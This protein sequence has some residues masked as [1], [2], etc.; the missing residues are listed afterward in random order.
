MVFS[1]CHWPCST[2]LMTVKK[3]TDSIKWTAA[4]LAIPT[5][6]G[7]FL[8]AAVNLIFNFFV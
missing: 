1:L 3:E 5:A 2:T 8:C 4:A 6:V 7:I